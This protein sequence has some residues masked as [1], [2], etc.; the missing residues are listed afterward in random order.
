MLQFWLDWPASARLIWMM[1][2]DMPKDESR[3]RLTMFIERNSRRRGSSAVLVEWRKPQGISQA[4][5]E[6]IA[7]LLPKT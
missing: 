1:F 5:E 6:E 2:T 3:L 4:F 7:K